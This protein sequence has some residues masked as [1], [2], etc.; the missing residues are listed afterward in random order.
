MKGKQLKVRPD[1]L[2]MYYFAWVAF[3]PTVEVEI[4][5]NVHE[6]P[7]WKERLFKRFKKED[8]AK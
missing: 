6:K 5:D 1:L 7:S 8:K 3:N 4:V 2:R